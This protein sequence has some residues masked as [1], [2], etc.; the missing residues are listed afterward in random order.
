M[1]APPGVRLSVVIV[2]W[3]EMDDVVR[4]VAAAHR[5]PAT[6]G[7]E[8]IVVDN[9]STDGTAERV[10]ELWPDV[11]LIRSPRNEGLTVGR[12]HGMRDARG[13]YVAM[14]DSDAWVRPG[15][16]ETLCAVL[17]GD[18]SI[19][20]VG[21]KLVYEDG[22]LQ[23]SC[24]RIPSPLA[25]MGNRVP[26]LRR[27]AARALRRYLMEDFDHRSRRDVDYVLG[28]TMVFRRDPVRRIGGFDERFG[29]STPGGYGFDDADWALRFRRQGY[30][31]VYEPEAVVVHR[32]RR[33]LAD[34]S[35]SRANLALAASYALMRAKH[36]PRRSAP[37]PA[38]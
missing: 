5:H 11:R 22:T 4:C 26:A 6:G 30:R 12:N 37:A 35:L 14:L 25:I 33:R 8:V 29:F 28:A 1:S 24:R 38:R 31:V 23:L 2:T 9:G 16:L 17:D 3:N 20:L 27:P 36:T 32:Y 18:A 15:A 7:Q 21:P 34:R 13:D 19:G 10:A